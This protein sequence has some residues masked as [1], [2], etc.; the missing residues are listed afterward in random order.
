M[1]R[2]L[3]A[4]I[5][6]MNTLISEPPS[7][8]RTVTLFEHVSVIDMLVSHSSELRAHVAH[9]FSATFRYDN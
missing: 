1:N 7:A 8:H 6:R 9:T 4:L 2:K 3:P 5:H